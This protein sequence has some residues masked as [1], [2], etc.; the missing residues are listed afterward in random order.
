MERNRAQ[1]QLQV[2]EGDEQIAYKRLCSA[3]V[4]TMTER[5]EA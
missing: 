3:V 4:S 2:G 5:R 1:S